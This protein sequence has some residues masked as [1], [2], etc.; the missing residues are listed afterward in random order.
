MITFLRY[1]RKKHEYFFFS[2]LPE[3][4]EYISPEFAE[5]LIGLNIPRMILTGRKFI[6]YLILMLKSKENT[7][8]TPVCFR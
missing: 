4:H 8:R 1:Y 3:K 7:I 5:L 2:E 6:K